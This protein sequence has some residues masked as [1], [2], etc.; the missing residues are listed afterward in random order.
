[1][2]AAEASSP[3]RRSRPAQAFRQCWTILL[4]GQR[5]L[6]APDSVAHPLNSCHSDRLLLQELPFL[7]LVR[8]CR[9]LFSYCSTS[10]LR[11]PLR[12]RA[13]VRMPSVRRISTIRANC[14]FFA[15][16]AHGN[17]SHCLRS[18]LS[19]LFYLG[20]IRI[21]ILRSVHDSRSKFT[22]ATGADEGRLEGR[23]LLCS[24]DRIPCP[25]PNRPLPPPA[26]ASTVG[27]SKGDCLILTCRMR[28]FVSAI[29]CLRLVSP[30]SVVALS[31]VPATISQ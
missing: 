26:G 7:V 24:V 23:V 31:N 4:G 27:P 19:L 5:A 3:Q 13:P 12:M 16:T 22:L 21:P 10:S 15:L 18:S 17:V 9:S 30:Q 20:G 14:F 11:C 2:D 8:A 25:A 28:D 29:S 1:M 6:T